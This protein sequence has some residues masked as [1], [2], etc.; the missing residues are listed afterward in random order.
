MRSALLNT[1]EVHGEATIDRKVS[2][3]VLKLAV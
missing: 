1:V 3:H 2:D